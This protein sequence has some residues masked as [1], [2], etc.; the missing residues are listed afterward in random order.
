MRSEIVVIIV[1]MLLS[2]VID[3]ACLMIAEDADKRAEIARANLEKERKKHE[4][5][6]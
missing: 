5:Q 1:V 2:A 3:W 6:D 4:H